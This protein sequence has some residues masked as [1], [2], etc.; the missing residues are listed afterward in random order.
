MR[1]SWRVAALIVGLAAV[2]AAAAFASSAAGPAQ[3]VT[4]LNVSYDP[5]R[6]FYQ[7][8]NAAFVKAWRERTGESVTINQSH[9]GSGKQA[10]PIDDWVDAARF[11]DGDDMTRD[12]A[13]EGILLLYVPDTPLGGTTTPP[14]TIAG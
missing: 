5:T 10:E 8:I 14:P 12:D 9:G 3:A 6:E 11:V 13:D 4:L 1:W 7:E 2:A